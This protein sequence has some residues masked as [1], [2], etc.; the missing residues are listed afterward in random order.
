MDWRRWDSLEKQAFT[1][2]PQMIS[3]DE[4]ID[5]SPLTNDVQLKNTK[6]Y[7]NVPTKPNLD[8]FRQERSKGWLSNEQYALLLAQ[9]AVLP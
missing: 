7:D 8:P 6:I 5:V 1:F 3:L 9:R 4:R 2:I